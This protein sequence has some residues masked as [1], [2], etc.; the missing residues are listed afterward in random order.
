MKEGI[1]GI[2]CIDNLSKFLLCRNA[3][4]RAKHSRG[5][6]PRHCGS[7]DAITPKR[8]YVII[9]QRRGGMGGQALSPPSFA[10]GS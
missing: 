10:P 4:L 6:H 8:C 3:Q 9:A 1:P 2:G 5:F 7:P